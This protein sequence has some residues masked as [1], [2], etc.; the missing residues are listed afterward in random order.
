MASTGSTLRSRALGNAL[1]QARAEH[2][3]LTLRAFAQQLGIRHASLSQWETG[4]GVPPI[5]HVARILTALGVD[6]DEYERIMGLAKDAHEPNWLTVGIPGVSQQLAGAVECESAASEITCWEPML[7]PGLLQTGN[8]ARSILTAAGLPRSEVE[9]L[10]HVRMGRREIVTR[11]DPAHLVALIGEAAIRDL[12]GGVTVMADQLRH[13]ADMGRRDNVV[14]QVVPGAVGWHPGLVG[15]VIFFDFPDTPS[16]V[17]LEHYRSGVFLADDKDVEDY[18]AA[19]HTVRRLAMSPE[20]SAGLIAEV[21]N[22]LET[23]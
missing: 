7:I 2:S 17:H 13:L 12:I 16:I 5:E 11:H 23:Q 19:V 14:I 15:P 22:K 1:R 3:D 8:Y 21:L 9:T 10:V 20:D 6:V 4:K 18:R